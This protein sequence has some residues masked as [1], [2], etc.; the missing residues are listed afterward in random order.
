M[1][2]SFR[3]GMGILVIE[4]ELSWDQELRLG[5]DLWTGFGE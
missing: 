1:G 5:L 3:F 4:K 2:A